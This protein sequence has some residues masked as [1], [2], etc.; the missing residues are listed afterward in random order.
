MTGPICQASNKGT[1]GDLWAIGLSMEYISD[2]QSLDKAI[3]TLETA[4]FVTVDTEFMRESTYWSKLCLIQIASEAHEYI[5]D[6]LAENIDLGR[7]YELMTNEAVVK[8]FHAAR[9]DVEIFHNQSGKIPHPLFDTQIAAMVC[10]YGESAGYETLVRE[11]VNQQLDKSSRF[12]DWSRRPLSEKQLSYALGDVTHL[13]T[14]YHSL[15][16]SLEE[17]DRMHWLKEEMQILTSPKTYQLD[18]LNAWKRL[19]FRGNNQR[20][21]SVLIA[22]AQWREILA[23]KHNVPRNR[24]LKDDGLYEISTHPT[25]STGD[26]A[27]LR[28]VPRGFDRG[29][30]AKSLIEAVASGLERKFD[31]LPE[32]HSK[33]SLPNGIGPI[34]ELLKV[35]LKICSEKHNVA[36]KLIATVSDLELIAADDQA[37]VKALHGW[38]HE[39]FGENAINLKHGRLMIG[40]KNGKARLFPGGS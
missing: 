24:I 4:P 22:L 29:P 3:T 20:T 28:G 33:K 39:L 36:Q 11:I 26:I 17:N 32:I 1:K 6:P 23:Q 31:T 5:I 10:G 2:S 12:T 30:Y 8:V 25:R 19:K 34:V 15:K 14:I 35:S 21:H 9:Q 16:Q 37:E 38:R 7:F 13:R 18:P 40:I 27:R